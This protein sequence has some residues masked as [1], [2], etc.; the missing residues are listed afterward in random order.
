MTHKH[1]NLIYCGLAL[2]LAACQ[3]ALPSKLPAPEPPPSHAV[4]VTPPVPP[5]SVHIRG[6]IVLPKSFTTQALTPAQLLQQATVS[7]VD[8][9]SKSV[10][11]TTISD[12]A[13]LF[14]FAGLNLTDGFYFIDVQK[15]EN[16]SVGNK[17]LFLRTLIQLNGGELNTATGPALVISAQTTA[18]SMAALLGQVTD[19]SLLLNKVSTDG[20][21][22]AGPISADVPLAKITDVLNK[23]NATLTGQGDPIQDWY[24]IS[25]SLSKSSALRDD[26]IE[27]NGLGFGDNTTVTLGG[28]P[29]Q[30]LERSGVKLKVKVPSGGDTGNLVAAQGTNTAQPLPLKVA[31]KISIVSGNNQL[32]L[33]NNNLPQPMVF[34]AQ[35][36]NNQPVPGV[37]IKLQ[38]IQ[39]SSTVPTSATTD[40]NGRA[41]VNFQIGGTGYQDVAVSFPNASSPPAQTLRQIGI[42]AY[43][44]RLFWVQAPPASGMARTLFTG[45]PVTVKT[46]KNDGT[47]WSGV[48]V[49]FRNS[50]NKYQFF[51]ALPGAAAT[52]TEDLYSYLTSGVTDANG[53]AQLNYFY[54]PES[55]C[56]AGTCSKFTADLGSYGDVITSSEILVNAPTAGRMIQQINILQG[57]NQSVEG[58]RELPIP[59]EVQA[60][61]VDGQP[62]P[63]VNLRFSFSQGSGTMLYT[64]SGMGSM[65]GS[66]PVILKASPS[67][68]VYIRL[69]APPTPQTVKVQVESVLAEGTPAEFSETINLSPTPILMP[70][71]PTAAIVMNAG[72][73]TD[74]TPS[75]PHLVAKVVDPNGNPLA[76]QTVNFTFQSGCAGTILTPSNPLTDANG[77]ATS[78]FTAQSNLAGCYG[79]VIKMTAPGVYGTF[80][81]PTI[82]ARTGPISSIQKYAGDNQTGTLGLPLVFPFNITIHDQYG[83]RTSD[84][85][86]L[87]IRF[88]NVIPGTG[89]FNTSIGQD[90]LD[91]TIPSNTQPIISMNYTPTTHG[92]IQVSATLLGGAGTLLTFNLNV[93]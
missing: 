30:I 81:A 69:V 46:V 59:L 41:S 53:V 43:G 10:R 34:E 51:S 60:M 8:I 11:S 85:S 49:I 83:N 63:N 76:N 72:A 74:G 32:G 21:T 15:R 19:Y 23:L 80:N 35:D 45:A 82:Y 92:N 36:V 17:S 2:A 16:G 91:L 1:H 12:G 24:V 14:S 79:T 9:A 28:Q 66:G 84:S 87:K 58:G 38:L 56:T 86:G 78:V 71:S 52:S 44:Q 37:P 13:G 5:K 64:K 77:L 42:A 61:G 55:A 68:K 31:T 27:I 89:Y 48:T 25:T 62:V 47:P 3:A 39:G 22:L 57:N 88:A 29:V 90:T 26:E 67:G 18:L 75:R 93:P 50:P 20:L 4:V 70:V 54:F 33:Q 6:Q 65:R 7:I 40:V 73:S